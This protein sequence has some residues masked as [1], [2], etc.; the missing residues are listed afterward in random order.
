M[1]QTRRAVVYARKS[2]KADRSEEQSASVEAQLEA[3]E[4]YCKRLGWPVVA[5]F[6][7]DGRS[8][9]LD[10]SRRPGL[11]AALKMVEAGD[12]DALVMLWK[13]RLSRDEVDR[14]VI[15]RDLEEREVEWHAVADGGL[16]DRSTYAGYIKDSADAMVDN[17]LSIRVREN[18]KRVHGRRLEDGMPKTGN[19]R[20]GYRR[21]LRYDRR[22]E[23]HYPSGPFEVDPETGP[24][25]RELYR[26]YT[27][28]AG[29]TPLVS[30]L[31]SKGI[32]TTTGAAWTVRSLS[33]M[34]DSGFAAGLISRE[35]E[36]RHRRGT[37]EHLISEEEWQAF[38]RARARARAKPRKA[39]APR[40]YLAG[41]VRCGLC[42]GSVYVNSFDSTK[43]SIECTNHRANPESCT[44]RMRVP[45]RWLETQVTIWFGDHF[46]ELA[47]QLPDREAAAREAQQALEAAQAELDETNIALGRLAASFARGAMDETAYAGAEGE[48]VAERRNR[49]LSL[50][51]A[52]DRLTELGP[53]AL[54]A[55]VQIGSFEGTPGEFGSNLAKVLLRVEVYPDQL[56]FVP[57]VGDAETIERPNLRAQA[58]RDREE[59]RRVKAAASTRRARVI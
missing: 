42:G 53:V 48:L 52:R 21:E 26:R 7:D 13:S 20:F 33:R 38:L 19:A 34:L 3:A 51:S 9:L 14:A 40:W 46:D 36:H 1:T 29:F 24:A 50:G 2:S 6:S 18:W 35:P 16:V 32:T 4:D 22:S 11:D 27:D 23:R 49:E 41:I 31:N 8:G 56:T 55:L 47:A 57:V 44:G 59:R 43:S 15:V 12:A 37:H 5:T 17:G 39:Q 28:G 25:V 30:W 54:D 58:A 10:R 45:R